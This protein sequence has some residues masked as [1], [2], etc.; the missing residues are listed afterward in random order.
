[1][2]GEKCKAGDRKWKRRKLRKGEMR[3]R[4]R[5]RMVGGCDK[6]ENEAEHSKSKQHSLWDDSCLD[7]C[8]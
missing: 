7:L 3:G 2:V 6:D 4:G 8:Q 1:M 5:L